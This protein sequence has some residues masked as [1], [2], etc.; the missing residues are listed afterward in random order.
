MS[1]IDNSRK[2]L[3]LPQKNAARCIGGQDKDGVGFRGV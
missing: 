3:C 2:N 1:I